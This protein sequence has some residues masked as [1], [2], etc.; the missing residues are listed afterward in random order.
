MTYMIDIP[1]RKPTTTDLTQAL[2]E[3]IGYLARNIEALGRDLPSVPAIRGD[4]MSALR[5]AYRAEG[6]PRNREADKALVASLTR[7]GG[8]VYV[9]ELVAVGLTVVFDT[10]KGADEQIKDAVQHCPALV[11]IHHQQLFPACHRLDVLTWVWRQCNEDGYPGEPPTPKWRALED[12]A[13]WLWTPFRDETGA[14]RPED[15]CELLADHALRHLSSLYQAQS[16][17]DTEVIAIKRMAYFTWRLQA[18]ADGLDVS[19]SPEDP[20]DAFVREWATAAAL[21]LRQNK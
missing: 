19:T 9:H 6:S 17:S 7:R 1:K 5:A 8:K 15:F 18:E 2:R 4:A 14:P 21:L 3:D 11:N 16:E 13:R 12:L 20:D 10:D